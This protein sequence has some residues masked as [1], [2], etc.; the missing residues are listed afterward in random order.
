VLLIGLAVGRSG[1]AVAVSTLAVAALFRPARARV[2][3]AVDRRF[4][5][6]RYDAAQ[7][8]AGFGARLRDQIELDALSD[9]L[10]GV[11]DE[12][13]QPGALCRCWLR[14]GC[15]REHPERV[16]VLKI[17]RTGDASGVQGLSKAGSAGPPEAG[18]QRAARLVRA[19]RRRHRPPRHRRVPPRPSGRLHR[20]RGSSA[21]AATG[22]SSAS[23]SGGPAAVDALGP[24]DG[25]FSVLERGPEE[26]AVTV[27]S[28]VRDV[29]LA[30]REPDRL[31]EAI[32]DPGVH[33]V[34]LTVTEK[35]YP[36]DRATGGL[37]LDDLE[38]ASD[39]RGRPRR[40][41]RSGSSPAASR[42][43]RSARRRGR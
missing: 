9:E 29:L 23:L 17:G 21:R 43:G 18:R 34:T 37:R 30:P 10:R 42:C 7:A 2:Q 27:I 24:Q 12:C 22:A 28:A 11:V 31:S 13:L 40:A 35:A 4:Y 32:A 3:A 20:R 33:V 15:E 39:P 16:S 6:R 5:R 25:L 41:P 1:F 14:A 36:R 26:D 19:A 8:L 38:V